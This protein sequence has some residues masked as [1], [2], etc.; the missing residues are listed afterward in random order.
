MLVSSWMDTKLLS[1]TM[2]FGKLWLYVIAY[3]AA[4]VVQR[5]R[6]EGVKTSR[7]LSGGGTGGDK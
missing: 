7:W 5:T 4:L 3:V 6:Q 1:A 2:V